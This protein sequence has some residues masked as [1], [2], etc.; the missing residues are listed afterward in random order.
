[1]TS[2]FAIIVQYRPSNTYIPIQDITTVLQYRVEVIMHKTP[3]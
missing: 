3:L 1:M 2:W